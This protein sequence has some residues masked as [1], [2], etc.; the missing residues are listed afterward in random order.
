MVQ[1]DDHG[2]SPVLL[3]LGGCLR[4]FLVYV[5]IYIYIFMYTYIYIYMYI[6]IHTH[7]YIDTYICLYQAVNTAYIRKHVHLF[8]CISACMSAWEGKFIHGC[9]H[10]L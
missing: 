3:A 2:C 10:F 9:S 4:V 8:I 6:Y 7:I 5:Y 1:M